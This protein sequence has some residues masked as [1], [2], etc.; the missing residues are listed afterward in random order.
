MDEGGRI[1]VD[2]E[3]LLR[4]LQ[5]LIRIDS[6]NPSLVAGGRGERQIAEYVGGFLDRMGLE[7]RLQEVA[8]GRVNAVGRLAGSGGGRSLIVNGHLDTVGRA[9]M[10]VDP[11]GGEWRDGKVFGRGS[12]D[13]KGGVAAAL[14]ALQ[15]LTAAGVRLRGDVILAGVA[16]E[17]YASIGTEALVKEYTADAAVVCEP[18]G[19]EIGVAHKGF[20]WISVEVQG[21][22]AHGSRPDL[23]IDAIVKA[24][25]VLSGLEVLQERLSLRRHRLL[26]APSVHASLIEGGT[27]M[28]TY[29]DRCRIRIERRTIPGEDRAAVA[30]ELEGLLSGI[31]SADA[32]FQASSELFF[33]RPHFE[34]SR[35]EPIVDTLAAVCRRLWRAEPRYCGFSGWLDSSILDQAGIPTVI[36][37][38]RG[39]G[40]HAAVEYVE[41]DSVA[42]VA[43]VLAGL[44]AAFCG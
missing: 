40:L 44:I 6:V 21:R 42:A 4:M 17:E 3:G 23:G 25:K 14:A 32:A 5:E 37:G 11:L 18:S 34:I 28:S 15:A 31:R 27:E 30:G 9:G 20:A 22:A 35:A 19:L 10:T 7:V 24:A 33:Y 2:R 38:P 39:E 41:F 26:G 29:P 16:D 1:Y 36:F 8:P 43:Q 12:L 13:M